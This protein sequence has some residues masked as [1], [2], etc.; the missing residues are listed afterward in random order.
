MEY[1]KWNMEDGIINCAML[2]YSLTD[3]VI[4]T[5]NLKQVRYRQLISARST[6]QQFFLDTVKMPNK[7][8]FPGLSF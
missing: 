7:V 6:L 2:V 8:L 1:G 3:V 4:A 5:Q